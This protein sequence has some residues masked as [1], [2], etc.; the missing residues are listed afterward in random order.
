MPPATRRL[1]PWLLLGLLVAGGLIWS[2]WPQTVPVETATVTRGPLRVEVTDEG[3]TRVREIYQISA[4][5]AGRL[6]RIEKHAGDSVEGGKTV[7]A[8]L[9]PASP[10]FLDVRTHAQAETAVKSATAM[11]D[12][13]AS[14]E[15]RMAAEL[16]F[17]DSDLK[18]AKKL[19]ESD[20]ISRASLERAELAYNVAVAQLATARAAL[21]TKEFDLQTAKAS[22]ID[23]TASLGPRARIPLIAP[24]SG[25]ILR[26]LH[27]NESVV[28]PGTPIMEVGDPQ[29]LEVVAP[30]ISED[31]VKIRVGAAALVTDWGGPEALEGRV[32]RIEPSG[33]TKASALGVEEQ[34]V[35]V[36]LDFQDTSVKRPPI[37]D[38][39]RVI[40]HITVWEN[41]DVLRVPA[42]AL[43]RSGK[44][45]AAFA[46]RNGRA[47]LTPVT[48][49][50]GNDSF[51]EVLRGLSA[52]DK[53][54]VHPSD[55]VHG[56]VKVAGVQGQAMP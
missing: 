27:E 51:S 18:R 12:L 2:F 54:I 37:A 9:L 1:L 46:I 56:G 14:F 42:S 25:R 24:V 17:A 45:W 6:L 28:A 47:A 49:G 32:R 23:P 10:A 52:G 3:R 20:A 34:R 35:N 48:V 15:K 8:D 29:M 44:G 53:V 38:G 19:A 11:R 50:H 22:L 30:F 40:V 41:P 43:F 7:V 13:A 55:R 31:A 39:Y 16:A 4:P 26:V 5:V 33:F 36:L 21:Q